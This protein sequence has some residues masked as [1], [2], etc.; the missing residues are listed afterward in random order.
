MG[1]FSTSIRKPDGGLESSVSG[2]CQLSSKEGVLEVP[3][4]LAPALCEW[5]LPLCMAR[6]T[7]CAKLEFGEVLSPRVPSK[8]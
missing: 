5:T 4:F 7:V 1:V 6:L 8:L 3:K 2:V